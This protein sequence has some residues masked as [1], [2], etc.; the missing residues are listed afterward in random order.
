MTRHLRHSLIVSASMFALGAVGAASGFAA[1]DSPASR[2][3]L[4]EQIESLKARVAQLEANQQQALNAQDVNQTVERVLRDAER[5]SKLLADGGGLTAGFDKGKFFLRSED[6]N[7]LLM[8][9]FLFQARHT[10]NWN[11]DDEDDIQSGFDIRRMRII[12]EGN[13]V[14]TDLQYKFQWETR[15]TDGQVFLQDAW[16]RYKFAKN[17]RFQVGQ[18]KDGIHHEEALADQFTLAADRSFVNAL[19][20]GGNIDRIQG[21]MLMYDDG[22]LRVNLVAHDGYNTKNTSFTDSGG[23][24]AFVGVTDPNFGF[25]ARAEYFL[26][27]TPRQYDDF[28]AMGNTEDLLV[29]G[30]GANWSQGGDSDVV[31][32]TV[33]A[34]WENA[35]G[36]GLYGALYAMWRDI[37]DGAAIPSGDYY[38]YGA[39]IQAGYMVVQRCEVFGRYEYIALDDGALVA[40]AEDTLHEVTVGTNYYYHGHNAKLTLDLS[41]LPNGS[42]TS[43][44][45]LGIA[46]GDDDQLILRL[47]AQLFL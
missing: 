9:G 34:Q 46:A 10:T 33:D 20:G 27:G 42:P 37:G 5:R 30:L 43:I 29:I 3:Q 8:P 4:L 25:S 13:A 16:A 14:S 47:Q 36:L 28:T 41:W 11:T 6:G 39:Q 22:K 45:L 31:F 35:A 7:W 44:G 18:F 19:I 32:H 38:D 26:S 23:G 21:A 15:N 2:E 17:L 12:F 40:G 1:D 24:T